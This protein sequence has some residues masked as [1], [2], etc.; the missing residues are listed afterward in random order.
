M[1]KTLDRIGAKSPLEPEQ[2]MLQG[3]DPRLPVMP[4]TPYIE[5]AY[6]EAL[7]HKWYMTS[8]FL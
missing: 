6:K 3:G 2:H 4:D 5:A 7:S 1:L 8:R